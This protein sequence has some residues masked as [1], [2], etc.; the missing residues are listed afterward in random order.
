MNLRLIVFAALCG[1]LTLAACNKGGS[2]GYSANTGANSTASN[3]SAGHS[4]DDGHGHAVA[5]AQAP[6][7]AQTPAGVEPS[8]IVLADGTEVKVIE[9]SVL[10]GDPKAYSGLVAISGEVA[11]VYADKGTFT[12][13]DCAKDDDCK[14]T[15][16]CGCCSKAQVPVRLELKDYDG[17]L[18]EAAQDVIVIA[19]V[20]P[21]ETGY[22]LAVREVRQGDKAILTKKV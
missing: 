1:V 11:T 20:S 6:A 14:T 7:E 17:A 10:D 18:P 5:E 13:K 8:S 16:S 15:D 22:S 9:A 2:T 21:T 4:A 19:E 3:V 12:L